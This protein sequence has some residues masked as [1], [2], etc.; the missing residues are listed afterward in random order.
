MY[1]DLEKVLLT[2]EEILRRVKAVATELAEFYKEKNPLVVCL[3]K[4]SSLFFAD[5]IRNMEIP[6]ELDFMAV[7]SYGNATRSSGEIKIKKDLATDMKDRDVLL[8][9]DIIDSGNTL[10]LLKD[11]LLARQPKDVKIVALL[12]KPARREKPIKADFCCFE[13]EDEFVVGYGMDYDEKY[14]N[15]PFV[16][17]LKRS[18]Y[19]K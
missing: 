18:V 12:D 8:V 5:L 16:G 6:M 14:R 11:V 9:E 7:S 13:I 1:N 4:G 2:E 3:L 17:I 10:Y 15:L 19:E